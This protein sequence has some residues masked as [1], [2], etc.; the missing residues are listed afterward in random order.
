[1][2]TATAG[3]SGV[4]STLDPPHQAGEPDRREAVL[5]HEKQ[6]L[7]ATPDNRFRPTE[8]AQQ[9]TVPAEATAVA[10]QPYRGHRPG[11]E[12][13]DGALRHHPHGGCA[14]WGRRPGHWAGNA[15]PDD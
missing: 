1:M 11:I 2:V 6:Q 15:E 7:H 9:V 13:I 5:S 10:A 4:C 12:L 14:G 3:R 8:Q